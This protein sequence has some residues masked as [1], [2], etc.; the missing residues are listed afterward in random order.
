MSSNFFMI[1]ILLKST[2]VCKTRN[3]FFAKF[4][5]ILKIGKNKL[6]QYR[7]LYSIL[8]KLESCITYKVCILEQVKTFLLVA[9]QKIKI[10]ALI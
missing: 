4:Y 2:L 3:T 9:K 5:N 8:C 7:I 6:V 1:K 10:T